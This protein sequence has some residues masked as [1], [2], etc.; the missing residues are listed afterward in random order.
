VEDTFL[1]DKHGNI[2]AAY[3]GLVDRDDV[4]SHIKTL[5]AQH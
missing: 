2:A 3:T 4:E 5:L 1:I